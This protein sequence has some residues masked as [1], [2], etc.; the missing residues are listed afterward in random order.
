MKDKKNILFILPQLYPCVTGGIEIFHYYFVQYLSRFYQIQIITTCDK[1]NFNNNTIRVFT[2]KRKWN[3][4][5]L[6]KN[7]F[8]LRYVLKKYK[9]IDL[10]HLPYS[11]K[12]LIQDYIFILIKKIFKIP[13][14]LRI[15]GGRMA[16]GKPHFMHQML[17]DNAAGI[18]AVSSPIKQEYEK[19]HGRK[20]KLIPSMLPF[21]KTILSKQQLKQKYNVKE[22]SL[23]V[24]YLGSIKEI[25]GPNILLSAIKKLDRWFLKQ[26]NI[27]FLFAGDGP[28]RS[29]LEAE[30]KVNNLT[31]HVIFLGN[32]PHENVCELYRLA[33]I[34]VIPSFFE[35]RPL[36]LSEA[37]YNGCPAIGSNISTIS[38][39]IQD[40]KNGFIF[41][42]GDS[43]DLAQKLKKLL[44]NPD[45]L[46]KF[47]INAEKSYKY[48]YDKMIHQY[49]SFYDEILCKS[50][51]SYN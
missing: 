2:Y 21:N 20:I 10:I 12:S 11:S 3:S 15:H 37:L 1:V 24:L 14:I 47:T 5:T 41:K 28:L 35:A 42:K 49:C 31:N 19:R 36:A 27:T 26:H 33:D 6:S 44:N 8:I 29:E 22:N 13:Y 4:S 43:N 18:V 51:V 48:N 16:L 34:F 30:V 17:F 40:G 25:K 50:N 9:K 32:I 45:M 46:E 7:V 39:L 23:V 38:N